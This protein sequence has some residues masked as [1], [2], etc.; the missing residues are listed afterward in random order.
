MEMER[1]LLEGERDSESSHVHYERDVFEQLQ[2]KISD[3]EANVTS[4]KAKDGEQLDSEVKRYDDLEFQQLERQ[5]RL[6]EEKENLSKQLL[7]EMA[8]YQQSIATRE[9]R[10]TSLGNQAG[11][12]VQQTELERQHFTKEK[13]NLLA[14][15]QRKRK[16][17]PE[18][19]KMVLKIK[20]KNRDNLLLDP[21]MW[22]KE[23]RAEFH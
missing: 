2:K 23:I 17:G 19:V 1:A 18:E 22:G 10:I 5:S 8:E 3:L 4:E 6:E 11:Q 9:K 20:D 12:I 13:N 15:L 16:E 7:C 21:E 14:M